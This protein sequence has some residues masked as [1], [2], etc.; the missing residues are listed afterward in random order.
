MSFIK[1]LFCSCRF[2]KLTL[3]LLSRTHTWALD[4]TSKNDTGE[5]LS[6]LYADVKLLCGKVMDILKLVEA[7]FPLSAA[8]AE[9]LA[10]VCLSKAVISQT[11]QK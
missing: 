7:A 6:I 2:W 1:L 11:K 9:S 3:Q 8:L 10:G 5:F 4:V